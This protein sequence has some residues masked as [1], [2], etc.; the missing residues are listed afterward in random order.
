MSL[1]YDDFRSS[2]E[3]GIQ[4]GAIRKY[5]RVPKDDFSVDTC[6]PYN[7]R[8]LRPQLLRLLQGVCGGRD[9]NVLNLG[10]GLGVESSE[11]HEALPGAHLEGVALSPISPRHRLVVPLD[12]QPGDD[13]VHNTWQRRVG[14][15][16]NT[17]EL[18]LRDFLRSESFLAHE[19]PYHT[20]HIGDAGKVFDDLR[21]EGTQFDVIYDREGPLAKSRG[22][23]SFGIR[24][25]H[26]PKVWEGA[27]SLMKPD[28]VV[29]ANTGPLKDCFSSGWVRLF[30][31]DAGF[32]AFGPEHERL[33]E[34]KEAVSPLSLEKVDGIWAYCDHEGK[35]V[36]GL[37]R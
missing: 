16:D 10:F 13:S 26:R 21:T 12:R 4:S 3:E 17:I 33:P 19:R 29:L 24:F 9:V 1:D 34:I 28:G 6:T 35:A 20:Q 31:K 8:Y 23:K 30:S 25:G 37:S 15:N 14:V 7:T 2:I 22:D 27:L 32:I 11:L 36:K 5:G 18:A